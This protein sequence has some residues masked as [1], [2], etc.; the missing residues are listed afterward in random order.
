MT[1]NDSRRSPLQ[2]ALVRRLAGR[3]SRPGVIDRSWLGHRLPRPGGSLPLLE[4][5]SRRWGDLT[6]DPSPVRRTLTPVPSPTPKP[7]T[8]V[9]SPALE[10]LTPDPSPTRSL[11][12]GRG[13]PPPA[14]RTLTPD[15]SPTCSLPSGRGAPPPVPG[16]RRPRPLA[17]D[18]SVPSGEASLSPAQPSSTPAVQ[19][20]G[21]DLG[22]DAGAGV[23]PRPGGTLASSPGFQPGVTT[24]RPSGPSARGTTNLPTGE[25][26]A[27]TP[28]SRAG[29]KGAAGEG[30]GVR[31]S[32]AGDGTG[33]RG[34]AEP[35][36]T[37]S[38]TGPPI[39][40]VE[41]RGT[42]MAPPAEPLPAV[43]PR[44]AP[45]PD[46]SLV[47]PRRP[48]RKPDRTPRAPATPPS[49]PRASTAPAVVQRQVDGIAPR[50][51]TPDAG[52]V[53]E[54]ELVERVLRK[55]MRRLEVEGERRGLKRW[56]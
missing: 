38:F 40:R 13:A 29:V 43:A 32:W 44:E 45:K 11:S 49:P 14:P 33:V 50:E 17:P 37:V 39:Q 52:G 19:F 55:L 54:E 30:S 42:A 8:P 21:G 26:R 51:P 4:S 28:L 9:P 31:V 20:V 25:G 10:T 53:D 22:E 47:T 2:P 36:A 6:S 15:P 41:R 5:W 27:G 18:A 23:S 56:P 1:A 16:D 3:R 48:N 46:M 24:R 7:L 35:H 12:P 34:S